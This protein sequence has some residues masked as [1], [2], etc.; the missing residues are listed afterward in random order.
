MGE[1]GAAWSFDAELA[2]AVADRVPAGAGAGMLLPAGLTL[3]APQGEEADGGQPL[4]R[5]R[6]ARFWRDPVRWLSENRLGLRAEDEGGATVDREPLELDGL[7]GWQL[8][9]ALLDAHDEGVSAPVAAAVL[10][11]AARCRW[12]P[13]ARGPPGP[14]G[15]RGRGHRRGRAPRR[16][17][18][19]P[20]RPAGP[21]HRRAGPRGAH[22]RGPAGQLGPVQHPPRGRQPRLEKLLSAW[23]HLL[24]W[25]VVAEGGRVVVRVVSVGRAP[26][27]WALA[28]PEADDAERLDAAQGALTWLLAGHRR[29]T[30][31]PLPLFK[32]TSAAFAAAVDGAGGDGG[33][34]GHRPQAPGPRHA[35][36]R[37]AWAGGDR[38]G[39]GAESALVRL[40]G[41][42]DAR[43]SRRPWLDAADDLDRD[44]GRRP[45]PLGARPRGQGGGGGLHLRAGRRWWRRAM[46]ETQP[47]DLTGPLP[48]GITVLE[49][50]AGTGKTYSIAHLLVRLVA[51][52][53]VGIEEVL[54]VTF[55]RL[56]T[57]ELRDRLRARLAEAA[58]ALEGE[59]VADSLLEAWAAGAPDDA[60]ATWLRRIQ[61]AREDFDAAA[62][63][64]I[65]SFCGLMLQT[66]AFESGSSFDRTLVTDLGPLLDEIVADW[67]TAARYGTGDDD[68]DAWTNRALRDACQLGPDAARSLAGQVVADLEV[69]IPPATGPTLA[70]WRA[71]LAPLRAAIANPDLDLRPVFEQAK[72][73][74]LLDGRSYRPGT[75]SPTG[76]ARGHRGRPRA[77]GRR[78]SPVLL[79]SGEAAKA[80]GDISL[81]LEHPVIVAL[82]PVLDGMEAAVTWV[83]TRCRGRPRCSTRASASGAS[84][85]SGPPPRAAALR[86]RAAAPPCARPSAPVPG[87][88]RRVPGHRH[89]GGRRSPPSPPGRATPSASASSSSATRSA[90]TFRG[91]N[92]HVYLRARK[93]DQTY[94][95]TRNFRSDAPLVAGLNH[96]MDRP[97]IFGDASG[98]GIAYVPVDTLD[99][100]PARL[101]A[102]GASVQIR[103]DGALVGKDGRDHRQGRRRPAIAE[104]VAAQAAALLSE[105][106]QVA[107]EAAPTGWRVVH[108]GDLAVLVPTH[109]H[110]QVVAEA[111]R[112][113]GV[114]ATITRSQ[115]VFASGAALDLQ[116]WL[117]ALNRPGHDACGPSRP[118]RWGAS[119][120]PPWPGWTRTAG[121]SWW[122]ASTRPGRPSTA[123]ASCGPSVS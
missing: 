25:T 91:A 24:A 23:V 123:S 113:A 3:P 41:P 110:A 2:R 10:Q 98:Q 56:A 97:G 78:R 96:L 95:M 6:L 109:G 15:A 111:L 120:R 11:G 12:A 103:L 52:E 54:V 72:A 34:S 100:A 49:A 33:R 5:A 102:A 55:T 21:C 47:F 58:A 46:S 70:E 90:T 89:P 18:R 118:R 38:T 76:T 108:P 81:L 77:R 117:Q 61:V 65:H 31:Q 50:S 19:S 122:P 1:A 92:V 27:V 67:L 68:L 8:S 42:P 104:D 94:T 121:A 75:P 39:E 40:F 63:S 57:A 64:T 13:R 71:L 80:K 99:R 35:G 119:T 30:L 37:E 59:P 62:V 73:A 20:A 9:R 88:H 51:E 85:A 28:L 29:G 4:P 115:S 32:K 86:I 114:P 105:G 112:A 66:S 53:G 43:W 26:D 84:R 116:R 87:A 74:K 7:Q 101:T 83:R 44:R 60:R 106:A 17:T 82:E 36:R 16:R 107:D 79:W 45:G 22:P 48:D 93:A 14:P 69:T